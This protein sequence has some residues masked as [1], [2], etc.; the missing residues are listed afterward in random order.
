MKN[1]LT[2]LFLTFSAGTYA[3]NADSAIAFY[4]KGLAEKAAK[5]WLV[6][7]GLFDKAVKENPAYI[8]AWLENGSVNLEMRKTDI[9][10]RHFLKVY[11]LDPNNGVAI[12]ELMDLYF[13][14]KR[15]K[16][17]I[18]FAQLCKNCIEANKVIAI[19]YFKQEDYN[20]AERM[21]LKLVKQFPADA[22]IQYTLG[23]TY[24]E[25]EL[26]TKAIPYYEK[27][28][29]LNPAKKDWLF[30]LGILYYNNNKF[31]NAVVYLNKAAEA[32]FVQSMDFKENLGYAYLYAGETEKGETLLMSILD[33]RRGSRDIMRDLALTFYNMGNYDKA[34]EYCQKLME[35]DM[36]DSKALY[37]AGLCFIKKGQKER[38]Q[39][40]CDKAIE[41]DPSLNALRQKQMQVGL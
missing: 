24:M 36:K 20:N 4:N 31:K 35:L 12:R 17:A 11:E 40:M 10:M 15:Y 41:M 26:E 14:Y 39:Q 23:R 32:G 22:D 38:G 19:S 30:E 18:N 6:A 8:A 33:K 37:Q 21:L 28:V 25:M 13:S 27:A 5:R 1:L 16:D 7:S 34:L 29:E 9:A 2:I 3:Q